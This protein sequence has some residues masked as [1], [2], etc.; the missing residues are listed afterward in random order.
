MYWGGTHVNRVCLQNNGEYSVGEYS[1][2]GM[3]FP[4][5]Q[6]KLSI[7]GHQ[8]WLGKQPIRHPL[9]RQVWSLVD[10]ETVRCVLDFQ[11]KGQPLWV[12]QQGGFMILF[13]A[14]I[15]LMAW[16]DV[17]QRFKRTT[18]FPL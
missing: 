5:P 11:P 6:L 13:S 18:V 1:N 8:L 10:G 12:K 16:A 7:V 14:L 2:I 4:H 15:V 17:I 9:T 3:S